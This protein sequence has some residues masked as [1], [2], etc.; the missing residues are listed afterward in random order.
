MTSD[1]LEELIDKHKNDDTISDKVKESLE[2]LIR[3]DVDS[4]GVVDWIHLD[5]VE[6]VKDF[7][8]VVDSV[9]DSLVDD[10]TFLEQQEELLDYLKIEQHYRMDTISAM[11]AFKTGMMDVWEILIFYLAIRQEVTQ[12]YEKLLD[13]E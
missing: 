6:I 1:L 12:Y 3:M 7:V 10:Y 8:S 11:Q 2:K 9:S 5:V 13:N 4:F